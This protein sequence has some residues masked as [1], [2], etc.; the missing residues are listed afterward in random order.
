MKKLGVIG[1]LGLSMVLILSGCRN[2]TVEDIQEK[3]TFQKACTESGG[4]VKHS[5]FN[6]RT[7][8]LREG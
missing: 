1:F 8:N 6:V 4:E 5:M 7:C 2:E 3:A